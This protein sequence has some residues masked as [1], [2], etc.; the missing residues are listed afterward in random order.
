MISPVLFGIRSKRLQV[1]DEIGALIGGECCCLSHARPA[2]SDGAFARC[3]TI[4]ESSLGCYLRC[5]RLALLLLTFSFACGGSVEGTTD[6]STNM[7]VGACSVSHQTRPGACAAASQECSSAD[8]GTCGTCNAGEQCA[9]DRCYAVMGP[10]SAAVGDLSRGFYAAGEGTECMAITSGALERVEANL[11]SDGV[12]AIVMDVYAECGGS[13][14]KVVEQRKLAAQFPG[15]GTG[16]HT[17]PPTWTID[18]PVRITAGT[19]IR[20]LFHAEGSR[21]VTGGGVGSKSG[22]EDIV[23]HDVDPNCRFFS[24]DWAGLP[25]RSSTNWDVNVHLY[26]HPQ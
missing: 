10:P 9:P 20:V 11:W 25:L 12:T 19:K 15:W 6:A 5:V 1:D 4:R 22:I 14:I 2:G 16:D 3:A 24:E 23:M 13:L 17:S 7:A 26:V 21:S 8:G 18:P